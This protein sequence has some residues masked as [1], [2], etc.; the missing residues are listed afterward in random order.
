MQK[1]LRL[2]PKSL[3]QKQSS[4]TRRKGGGGLGVVKTPARWGARIL[5]QKHKDEVVIRKPVGGVVTKSFLPG[6]CQGHERISSYYHE[7]VANQRC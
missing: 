1:Y 3:C 6:A 4:K 5:S 7:A 2:K